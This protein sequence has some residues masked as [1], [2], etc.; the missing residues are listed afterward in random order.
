MFVV[1]KHS[2][3]TDLKFHNRTLTTFRMNEAHK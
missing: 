1:P 3:P 2:V